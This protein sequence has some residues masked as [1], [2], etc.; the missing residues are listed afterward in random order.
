MEPPTLVLW[1]QLGEFRR[2]AIGL[3][4]DSGRGPVLLPILLG[5][6]QQKLQNRSGK[7][8]VDSSAWK[9]TPLETLN[10]QWLFRHNPAM[11]G[12]CKHG[13]PLPNKNAPIPGRV[14]WGQGYESD[15]MKSISKRQASVE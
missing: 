10:Q 1:L 3:T 5:Y 7:D 9:K 13:H 15:E 14:K 6:T 8:Q 11:Q 12:L 2:W 4:S